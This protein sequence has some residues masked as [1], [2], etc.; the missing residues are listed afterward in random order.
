MRINFYENQVK[1]A[2]GLV[3]G[4]LVTPNPGFWNEFTIIWRTFFSTKRIFST[5]FRGSAELFYT[6][7]SCL[8]FFSFNKLLWIILKTGILRI[9]WWNTWNN[10]RETRNSWKEILM[11][12]QRK[13][14]LICQIKSAYSSNKDSVNL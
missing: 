12:Y 8:S 1:P 11:Y 9:R 7:Y 2:A 3:F 10:I 13:I 5:K 4:D 14:F 6:C